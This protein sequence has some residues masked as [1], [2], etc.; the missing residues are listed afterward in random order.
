MFLRIFQHLLP[1][2]VAWVLTPDKQIRQFFEGLTGLGSDIKAYA[3][4]VW[5]DIFPATTREIESWERQFGLPGTLPAEQDRRDR[6]DA[7]WKALGG[8][9]PRYIQDTLQAAG[10]DV[11]VHEWWSSPGPPPVPRSPVLYL[12]DGT[13]SYT[14][15]CGGSLAFCGGSLA[16]CGGSTTPT[17]FVLVNKLT[18]STTNF[19]TSGS[20][21]ATCGGAEATCGHRS[22]ETVPVIYPIPSDPAKWPYFLYFGGQ[23]FP[24]HAT[25]PLNRRD[26]FEALCLKLAPTQQWLGMLIDYT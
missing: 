13:P 19:L 12:S 24:D 10:F 25:I 4:L 18:V 16:F 17:G 2:A 26:E 6:L 8:Q 5:R 15:R 20:A 23:V 1:Q 14:V 7:A 22:V 21:R 3:D 9:S 11:Y